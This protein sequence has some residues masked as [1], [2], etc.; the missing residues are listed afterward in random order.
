M[1][2]Q[3][4]AGSDFTSMTP[5]LSDLAP[6][7]TESKL[8]IYLDCVPAT[9]R[10]YRVHGN[11]PPFIK[12]GSGKKAAVRYDLAKVIAWLEEQTRNNTT[13]GGR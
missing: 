13:E 2:Q 4:R 5:L 6:L 7:L 9:L 8:A 11:G 1:Q 12:L 3:K 10:G